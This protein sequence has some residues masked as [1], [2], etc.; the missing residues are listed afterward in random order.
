[1]FGSTE[2]TESAFLDGLRAQIGKRVRIWYDVEPS[3]GGPLREVAEG[4]LTRVDSE[5]T[6]LESRLVHP[7]FTDDRST[8]TA[9]TAALRGYAEVDQR[10]G[11]VV[12]TVLRQSRS[13]S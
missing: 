6:L 1:M 2:S 9:P 4:R 13:S 7:S 3:E 5:V 11:S 10:T 8:R 12:R